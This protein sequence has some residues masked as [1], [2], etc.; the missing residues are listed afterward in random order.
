MGDWLEEDIGCCWRGEASLE[1]A[2]GDEVVAGSFSSSSVLRVFFEVFLVVILMAT[3]LMILITSVVSGLVSATTEEARLPGSDV[4]LAALA[5]LSALLGLEPSGFFFTELLLFSGS[6][7]LETSEGF[8]AADLREKANLLW[9]LQ[10]P[11]LQVQGSSL[12]TLL[13]L[14]LGF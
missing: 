3:K 11:T 10:L 2:G 5:S 8:L 13:G 4:S 9:T 12:G 6:S 7:G 1:T 14:G